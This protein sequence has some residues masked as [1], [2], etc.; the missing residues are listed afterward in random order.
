VAREEGDVGGRRVGDAGAEL[1]HGRPAGAVESGA[2]EVIEP[3][4]GAPGVPPAVAPTRMM[5]LPKSAPVRV[6]DQSIEQATL[7]LTPTPPAT[8]SKLT[9]NS[10]M[11]FPLVV[12]IPVTVICVSVDI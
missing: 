1:H 3:A 12:A 2:R 10:A 8:S 6:S 5:K 11:T 4:R 9:G 7:R